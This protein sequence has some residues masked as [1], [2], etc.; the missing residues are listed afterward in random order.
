MLRV[1]GRPWG[2]RS[3]G[4]ATVAFSQDDVLSG[5]ECGVSLTQVEGL[6]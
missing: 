2:E 6:G 1:R 4:E 5:A 3:C